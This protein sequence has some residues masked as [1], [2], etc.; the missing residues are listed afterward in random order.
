MRNIP[1]PHRLSALKTSLNITPTSSSWRW[2]LMKVQLSFPSSCPHSLLWSSTNPM[3]IW[4]ASWDTTRGIPADWPSFFPVSPGTLI[5][6][7]H[8][9]LQRSRLKPG[10]NVNYLTWVKPYPKVLAQT[11]LESVFK[12]FPYSFMVKDFIWLA[13]A[14]MLAFCLDDSPSPACPQQCT[15]AVQDR[16]HSPTAQQ[17]FEGCIFLSQRGDKS[18][19]AFLLLWTLQTNWQKNPHYLGY[20][21]P[22]AKG[23]TGQVQ[24]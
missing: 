12:S 10:R 18:Y 1:S 19:Q 23:E 13:D 22:P 15:A 8:T 4:G 21:L 24:R 2:D 16:F 7:A 20:S 9:A 14:C 6:R 17:E 3:P 11:K 5:W